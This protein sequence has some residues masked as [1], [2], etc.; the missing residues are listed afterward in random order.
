[1]DISFLYLSQNHL[2]SFIIYLTK[3]FFAYVIMDLQ[4]G[5]VLGCPS[6]T[7]SHHEQR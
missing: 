1:V 7:S 2:I 5:Q 4:F 3:V 6:T